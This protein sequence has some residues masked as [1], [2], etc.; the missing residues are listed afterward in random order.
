MFQHGKKNNQR[1]FL[2]ITAGFFHNTSSKKANT[3]QTRE[4]YQLFASSSLLCD[5]QIKSL[6]NQLCLNEATSKCNTV[7]KNTN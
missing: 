6:K 3:W 5:F 1:T 7:Q 4:T 2:P